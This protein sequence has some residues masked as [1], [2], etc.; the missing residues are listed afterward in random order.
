MLRARR[1][2]LDFT[3]RFGPETKDFPVPVEVGVRSRNV[4]RAVVAA[5]SIICIS[6]ACVVVRPVPLDGYCFMTLAVVHPL[7]PLF[8]TSAYPNDLPQ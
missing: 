5:N 1:M 6:H 4:R 8:C 7:L 3:R 2:P